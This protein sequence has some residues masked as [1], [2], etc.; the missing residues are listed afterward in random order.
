MGAILPFSSP[1]ALSIALR[2]PFKNG[3]WGAALGQSSGLAEV[4]GMVKLPPEART[5]QQAGGW[6][7]MKIEGSSEFPVRL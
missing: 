5:P 2:S 3:H 4:K 7:L 1:N 6:L